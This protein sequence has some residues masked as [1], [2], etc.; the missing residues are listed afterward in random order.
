MYV[1]VSGRWVNFCKMVI[2]ASE[3]GRFEG[4]REIAAD[5]QCFGISV[6]LYVRKLDMANYLQDGV[7]SG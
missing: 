7:V 2:I 6:R 3:I 5:C 1:V 4:A